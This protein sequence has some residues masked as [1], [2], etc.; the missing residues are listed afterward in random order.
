MWDVRRTSYHPTSRLT[1]L[2]ILTQ[3]LYFWEFKG[4]TMHTQKITHKI[5]HSILTVKIIKTWGK[6]LNKLWYIHSSKINKALK[7][8]FWEPFNDMRKCSSR[9]VREKQDTIPVLS[10]I[11]PMDQICLCR[12]T[13]IH[14]N[15]DS[16]WGAWSDLN[17]PFFMPLSIFIRNT[18]S[19]YTYENQYLNGLQ[20]HSKTIITYFLP[21]S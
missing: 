11:L 21:H 2:H 7:S 1:N 10:M 17:C 19:F 13:K 9:N 18:Y 5:P 8:C 12:S 20:V 14:K 4:R 6:W 15:I 3:E 16:E